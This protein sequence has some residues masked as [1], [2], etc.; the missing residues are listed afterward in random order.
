[1]NLR[2][3]CILTAPLLLVVKRDGL[4]KQRTGMGL[5]CKFMKPYPSAF[6]APLCQNHTRL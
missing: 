1:M 5:S 2:V 4:L 3:L 6:L